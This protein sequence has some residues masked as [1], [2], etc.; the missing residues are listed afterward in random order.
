MGFRINTNIDSQ[1]ATNSLGKTNTMLSKSYERLS[2][3][4]RINRASDDAAGLAISSKLQANITSYNQAIRNGNDAVSVIQTAEGGLNEIYNNLSRIRELA[5]Q[6]SSGTV[7]D[8]ERSYINS[9]SVALLTEIT[10]I[11][12]TSTFNGAAL[13]NGASA[14]GTGFLTMDIQVGILNSAADRITLNFSSATSNALGVNTIVLNTSGNAQSSIASIDSAISLV[15]NIRSI[16]GSNQ[17]RLN[18][19]I[20]S[21]QTMVENMSAANNQIRDVDFATETANMSRYQVLQQ[22]GISILSQA[23]SAPQNALSLLR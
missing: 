20:S 18:S 8:A 2:T 23:N 4:L 13:I 19:A 15:S 12:N 1:K 3:G 16:M 21:M 7:T 10:R 11:A 17:N 22:A 5:V 9:E 6:G 14:T